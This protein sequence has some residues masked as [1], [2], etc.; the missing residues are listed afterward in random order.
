L[1]AA[2][3]PPLALSGIEPLRVGLI[4]Y[5][6]AGAAFHAPLIDA[7]PG[8]SLAAVVTANAERA[9]EV[10]R[11]HPGAAVLASPDEL[12]DDSGS[13]DVVVVAAPNRAHVPLALAALAAGL[14]VV[15]DKPL[16]ASVAEASRLVEAA[17][18]AGRVAAVFHNRRWD[19]DFRTLRRLV[20]ANRLGSLWRLESRFERWRPSVRSESWRERADPQDAGGLLF[21][22]GSHLID[23]ALLLC[24]PVARVFAE[25]EVRRPGASVDD[26]AFVALEHRGGARTHLW[27]SQTAAQAGP[28]FRALG[29]SGAYVKWGLDVQEAALRAGARAD[30][31]GF[32][33]ESS[34]AW[35]TVGAGE[36]VE[37]VETEPGRYL[38]FYEE[39]E[40]AIRAG[41][42]PP[43]PLEAGVAVLRVIEAALESARGGVV[44]EL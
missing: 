7:V 1:G 10:G 4:G 9:A 32:G 27:M 24:G 5:G 38:G 34:S 29:S 11:A 37:P 31:P 26:D 41:A 12:F 18:A 22:L 28:R 16:A 14:H 35:G 13:H 23:Q 6:V 19:G 33:V 42:P 8:L 15:V 44:A 2:A 25:L 17:S 39:L 3:R 36:D 40:R 30:S 21:D 20:A 43:V